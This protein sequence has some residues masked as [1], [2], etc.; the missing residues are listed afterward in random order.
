MQ[1]IIIVRL[2]SRL[3]KIHQK[4]ILIEDY[5]NRGDIFKHKTCPYYICASSNGKG[6]VMFMGPTLKILHK[7]ELLLK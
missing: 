2:Y 3:W 5:A 4:Y 1:W 7:G 6:Y